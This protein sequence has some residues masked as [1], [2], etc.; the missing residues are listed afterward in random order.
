M[1][2]PDA[3]V[4]PELAPDDVLVRMR[5]AVAVGVSVM[6]ARLRRVEAGRAVAGAAVFWILF[7]DAAPERPAWLLW[8][9]GPADVDD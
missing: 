1:V 2:L 3:A 4:E 6:A 5:V 9:A 8:V 7:G